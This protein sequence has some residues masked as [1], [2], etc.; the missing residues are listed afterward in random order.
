MTVRPSPEQAIAYVREL[1][2]GVDGVAVVA[3]DGGV[4]AEPPALAAPAR[5]L[6]GALDRG[7]LRHPAGFAL[8][9]RGP[10]G[11]ALVVAG[12]AQT[13]AG[14]TALD[15]AVAVA[16]L[17]GD[18]AEAPPEEVAEPSDSA[19]DAAQMASAAV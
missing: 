6:A 10:A 5:A 18:A 3:P 16:A 1:S 4:H 7:W 2:T 12:V 9:A 15:A 17:T 14:P 13:L 19:L 8:V 11:H